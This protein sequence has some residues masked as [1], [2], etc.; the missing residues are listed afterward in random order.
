MSERPILDYNQL[1]DIL[2]GVIREHG[3][4]GE[5]SRGSSDVG[6]VRQADGN[7]GL[8]F[9]IDFEAIGRLADSLQVVTAMN[10]AGNLGALA[11]LMAYVAIMVNQPRRYVDGPRQS[12]HI[13]PL[14]SKIYMEFS[15]VCVVRFAQA[16]GYNISGI[17]HD[18]LPVALLLNDWE[19]LVGIFKECLQIAM[20]RTRSDPRKIREDSLEPVIQYYEEQFQAD[21][22]RQISS[23]SWS[24]LLSVAQQERWHS[25]E[26]VALVDAHMDP[27]RDPQFVYRSST[28]SGDDW[29][30]LYD[31]I[32]RQGGRILWQAKNESSRK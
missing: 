28:V 21:V 10:V 14:A 26:I 16:Y 22:D 19:K 12:E 3:D 27:F 24:N 18:D 11:E 8:I 25:A 7:V 17:R 29:R 9:Q 15:I 32:H 30:R 20:H 13:T 4:I 6:A 2:L 5:R 31:W 1:K 23:E